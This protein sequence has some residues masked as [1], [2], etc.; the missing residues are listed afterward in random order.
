MSCK[1]QRVSPREKSKFL[2]VVWNVSDWLCD[3]LLTQRVKVNFIDPG[4]N[5]LKIIIIIII[6]INEYI[7]K[8]FNWNLIQETKYI[9]AK[10]DRTLKIVFR[11]GRVPIT[12]AARYNAWTVFAGSNAGIVGSDPTQ[13][14]DV[15][16][17]LFCVC[18]VVCEGSGLA[19]G[20]SPVQGVLP[21][22]CILRNW[23]SGQGP[24]G[25]YSHR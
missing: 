8:R 15:C 6:I 3:N 1:I 12:E 5:N 14:M 22:V 4:S 13:G 21:T 19:T 23:K 11:T 2:M 9:R 18:V 25:P 7:M 17:R 24:Q 20:W 16:V 10:C